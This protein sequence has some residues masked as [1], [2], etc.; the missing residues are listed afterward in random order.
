MQNS[1]DPESTQQLELNFRGGFCDTYHEEEE[2]FEEE[3]TRVLSMACEN[4]NALITAI[5]V[6]EY[7]LNFNN[8]TRSLFKSP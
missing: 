5:T 7:K 3:V 8:I 4:E 6:E 2:E 1:F